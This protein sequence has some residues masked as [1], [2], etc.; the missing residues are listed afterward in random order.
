MPIVPAIS[1]IVETYPVKPTNQRPAH[2]ESIEAQGDQSHQPPLPDHPHKAAHTAYQQQSEQ[3]LQAKP[4]LLARDLMS[5]PVHTLSSEST[6]SEAWAEMMRRNVHHLPITSVHGILVGII[7]DRDVLRHAPEVTAT[8]QLSRAAQ[9]KLADIMT[10]RVVSAAP[11]TNVRDIAR[12]M[13]DER[14]HAVPI[15][16]AHRRLVGILTTR[17]LLRGIAN[18]GPLELWT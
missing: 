17:D 6:A 12:L 1:G 3:S 13:L 9:Q 8:G 4:V 18:H 5:S 15:L 7:S 2:V 14:I 10:R 11:T 16:D